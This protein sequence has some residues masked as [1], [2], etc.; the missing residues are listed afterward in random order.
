MVNAY[1]LSLLVLAVAGA[2]AGTADAQQAPERAL[3]A[4]RAISSSD[5]LLSVQ[6]C[7][8]LS[9]AGDAECIEQLRRTATDP[10][11]P[12]VA[13]LQAASALVQAGEAQAEALLVARAEALQRQDPL[14]A[15]QALGSIRSDS[16]IPALA[17]LLSEGDVHTQRAAAEAL[18]RQS[19]A[20]AAPLKALLRRDS[21]SLA[22][23]AA[24]AALVRLGDRG[25]REAVVGLLPQLRGTDLLEPAAAL[26]AVGDARGV[27]P[28]RDVANG[29]DE[30]LRLDAAAALRPYDAALADSVID[31]GL[32]SPN[33]WVRAHA[34][35]ALRASGRAADAQL[36]QLLQDTNELVRLRAAEAL[37]QSR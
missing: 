31:A 37:G 29:P 12:P 14:A 33:A 30:M 16:V 18:G 25:E 32:R 17:R 5:P 24:R 13:Q 7:G 23:L 8:V 1:F 15:T 28:L 19:T 27:G 9:R 22:A 36:Q 26:L 20:A 11:K 35:E 34:I 10:S 6:R 2:G 4:V 3:A 21:H